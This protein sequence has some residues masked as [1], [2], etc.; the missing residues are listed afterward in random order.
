MPPT[1]PIVSALLVAASVLDC[2]SP[3][4]APAALSSAVSKVAIPTATSQP[5]K[6]Q[7]QCSPPNSSRWRCCISL[8]CSRAGGADSRVALARPF[9]TTLVAERLPVSD[10]KG[11]LETTGSALDRRRG[12][13][14]QPVLL[15]CPPARGSNQ[16]L[17]RFCQGCSDA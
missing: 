6:A 5:K 2:V 4:A 16:S 3:T 11:S 9:S 10:M 8:T 15:I 13:S 14:H 17:S 12:A 1:I 7:P